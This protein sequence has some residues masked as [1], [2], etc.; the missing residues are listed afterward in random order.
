MPRAHLD[1]LG[2]TLRVFGRRDLCYFSSPCQT[3][4]P[5]PC[6]C[7][8]KIQLLHY[9]RVCSAARAARASKQR[10]PPTASRPLQVFGIRPIR[11]CHH[12]LT[13]NKL[14]TGELSCLRTTEMPQCPSCHHKPCC[15]CPPFRAKTR[16]C[17][18][19]LKSAIHDSIES[20]IAICIP[21][22]IILCVTGFLHYDLHRHLVF[23]VFSNTEPP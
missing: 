6:S 12:G 9:R 5:P 7:S 18:E 4:V 23:S 3:P 19:N 22:F 15:C 16:K 17:H 2:L 8:K 21:Y 13:R 10:H 11:Q 20:L 1:Q 14:E